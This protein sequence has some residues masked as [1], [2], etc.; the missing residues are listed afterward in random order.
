MLSAGMN[1]N[2]SLIDIIEY[3][4][5]FIVSFLLKMPRQNMALPGKDPILEC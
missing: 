4:P 1:S 5:N 2:P 3:L